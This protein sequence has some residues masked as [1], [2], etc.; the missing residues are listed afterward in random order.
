MCPT[1]PG[2]TAARIGRLGPFLS[3]LTR[4]SSWQLAIARSLAFIKGG[5]L[6][7]RCLPLKEGGCRTCYLVPAALFY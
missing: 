3:D 5:M 7:C 1:R 4:L 2:G 6:P